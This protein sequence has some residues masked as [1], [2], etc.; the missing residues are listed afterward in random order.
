VAKGT[1][2][3]STQNKVPGKG[4]EKVVGGKKGGGTQKKPSRE[5]EKK[6]K[7]GLGQRESRGVLGR[8]GPGKK[9]KL[10]GSKDWGR[11]K[12]AAGGEKS[13]DQRKVGKERRGK[14]YE[15]RK[16]FTS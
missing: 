12:E 6:E 16:K 9:K 10:A 8:G 14:E 7:R 3:K 11:T 15:K 4:G 2:E 1:Y 5:G 13:N